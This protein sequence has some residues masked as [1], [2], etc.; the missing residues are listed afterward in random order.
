MAESFKRGFE[1]RRGRKKQQLTEYIKGADEIRSYAIENIIV[2]SAQ[3]QKLF[4]VGNRYFIFKLAARYANRR[5]FYRQEAAII[6]QAHSDCRI[7]C[8]V[9]LRN[10]FFAREVHRRDFPCVD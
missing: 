9:A 5:S 10:F 3:L 7:A 2:R 1:F 8:Q 6:F 4:G